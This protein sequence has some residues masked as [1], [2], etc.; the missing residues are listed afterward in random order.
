[1]T[2]PVSAS[3]KDGPRVA[4][5]DPGMPRRSHFTVL[6]VSSRE[7]QGLQ[8]RAAVVGLDLGGAP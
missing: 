8:S 3:E 1:M 6:H 4:A 2:G 7:R 5:G